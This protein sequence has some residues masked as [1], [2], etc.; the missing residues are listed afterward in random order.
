M[1]LSRWVPVRGKAANYLHSSISVEVHQ[2]S[3]KVMPCFSWQ[4]WPCK[5]SKAAL[6]PKNTLRENCWATITCAEQTSAKILCA[7]FR[8]FSNCAIKW[9]THSERSAP[10]GLL[11]YHGFFYREHYEKFHGFPFVATDSTEFSLTFWETLRK[12]FSQMQL[13]EN[14]RQEDK[15][16]T[17]Q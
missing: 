3:Q 8:S 1:L 13:S 9:S 6:P 11:T 5:A 12:P 14:S 16:G 17:G 4:L 15:S 10:I 7:V 2:H